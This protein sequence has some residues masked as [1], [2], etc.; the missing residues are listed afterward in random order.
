MPVTP[1]NYAAIARGSGRTA[2]HRGFGRHRDLESIGDYAYEMA[3]LGS[4][5][6]SRLL[7]Q[8]SEVGVRIGEILSA[9]IDSWRN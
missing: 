8:N 6:Q 2:D 1:A 9:A 4:A 7:S 3:G 5:R